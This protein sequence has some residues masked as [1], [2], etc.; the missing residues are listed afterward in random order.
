MGHTAESAQL[1]HR[2]NFIGV[3]SHLGNT[4]SPTRNGVPVLGPYKGALSVDG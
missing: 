3:S 2:G 1:A 4:D